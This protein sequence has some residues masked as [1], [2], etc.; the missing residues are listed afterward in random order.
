MNSS[1][2]GT[3][4]ELGDQHWAHPVIV[5]NMQGTTIFTETLAQY[6]AMMVGKKSAVLK[7]HRFLKYEIGDYLA[8]RQAKTAF[9]AKKSSA[10]GKGLEKAA[11]F[12]ETL[13]IEL[14]TAQSFTRKTCC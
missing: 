4:H 13:E 10:D 6:S 5:A 3:A 7:T 2:H 12:N 11:L 1:E 14:F 8:V 9:M